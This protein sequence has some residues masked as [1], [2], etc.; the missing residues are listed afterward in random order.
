MNWLSVLIATGA[1]MILGA[2][3][4]SPR[5][6]GTAW[7]RAIGKSETDLGPALWPMLGS[8][9][10]SFL[11]ALALAILFNLTGTQ[12]VVPGATV[13]SL[14]GV[15]IVFSAFLSDNLFCG[16]GW[17]LLLIQAGYRV[18]YVIV[19]AAIIGGWPR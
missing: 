17:R 19:M 11:T 6:F 16:W 1:G 4:Y 10:A 12:G 14:I 3:W 15:G 7:L 9:I 5:I 13:G 8:V 18:V 2:L